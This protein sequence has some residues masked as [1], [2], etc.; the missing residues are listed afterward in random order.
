[1][2]VR[3]AEKR[4]EMHVKPP[5][6]C[7]MAMNDTPFASS[8]RSG[9]G[10]AKKQNTKF[11]WKDWQWSFLNN[12]SGQKHQRPPA[13]REIS[14]SAGNVTKRVGRRHRARLNLVRGRPR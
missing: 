12:S 10:P 9:Q 11:F 8:K 7:L 1:M 2:F 3:E 5:D 13:R 4:A 14:L 6:P